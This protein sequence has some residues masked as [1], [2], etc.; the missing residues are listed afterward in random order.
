M[1]QL[2]RVI[3]LGI[4]L[5]A[6]VMAGCGSANPSIIKAAQVDFKSTEISSSPTTA[7]AIP[8]RYTCDGK[9]IPPPVEWGPVPAGTGELVL[10]ILGVTPG[11]QTRTETISVEWAVAGVNPALH[12]L[13][14]ILPRG[15]HPGLTSKRKTS[16]SICPKRGTSEQYLFE[17]YGLPKGDVI[18]PTFDGARVFSELAITKG[19]T[20]AIAHG[21]FAAVYRRT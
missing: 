11:S 19:N 17:L 3:S 8:S 4:L 21:N 10:F 18:S 15:A 1:L 12:H 5:A 16:Y 9:N 6:S 7:S 13:S 14:A 20:I 2:P